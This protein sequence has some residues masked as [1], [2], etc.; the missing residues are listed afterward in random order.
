MMI[1]TLATSL[2]M[3]KLLLPPRL[4][5]WVNKD[6][7]LDDWMH[8]SA[9]DADRFTDWGFDQWDQ[10]RRGYD[11]LV[12]HLTVRIFQ[13][14]PRRVCFSKLLRFSLVDLKLLRKFRD[15]LFTTGPLTGSHSRWKDQDVFT[16]LQNFL[17][18]RGR[19]PGPSGHSGRRLLPGRPRPR[20]G[21]RRP[22]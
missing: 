18:S 20:H 16:R 13:F 4:L 1:M 3:L 11:A 7:G 19:R 9:R 17:G 8:Q 12:H 14:A 5:Q 15:Y 21:F 10:W 22:R 2:S 6:T